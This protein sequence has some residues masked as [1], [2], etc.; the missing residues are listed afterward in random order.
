MS[1]GL[2][3][4]IS[5]HKVFKICINKDVKYHFLSSYQRLRWIHHSL[6][7]IYSLTDEIAPLIDLQEAY[8]TKKK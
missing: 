5:T 8:S 6:L 2:I 3:R 7:Q 1:I 4:L